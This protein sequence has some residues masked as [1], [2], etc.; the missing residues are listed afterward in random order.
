MAVIATASR[1]RR[2]HHRPGIACSA[3]AAPGCMRLLVLG[4][5]G[6]SHE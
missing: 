6:A 2:G 4:D 1:V 3:G 5:R